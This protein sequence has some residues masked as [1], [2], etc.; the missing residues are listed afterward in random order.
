MKLTLIDKKTLQQ[1]VYLHTFEP[2]R[3]LSWKAGQQMHFNLKH[4]IPD[5]LGTRR[6]FS[7]ASAP[8]EKNVMV[9]TR[10]SPQ[11]STFKRFWRA[12]Q[13]GES[14]EA[15]L[16]FG[17]FV[18]QDPKKEYTLIAS[19]IGIA[20]YRSMLMDMDQRGLSI[21]ATLLYTDNSEHFP[22]KEDIEALL[23][24]HPRFQVFYATDPAEEEHGRIK[25]VLDGMEDHPIY[26]SGIYIRKIATMLD[27]KDLA[28]VSTVHAGQATL[29][30]RRQEE[31][32]S[33][34]R[35]LVGMWG[36]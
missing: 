34:E 30:A 10:C 5:N 8:F 14:I 22:F 11:G 32:R 36:E 33:E 2:E 35:S 9:L 1:E 20:P 28:P 26:M 27:G 25:E 7:I 3:P 29:M 12:I 23:R 15:D 17:D 31:I 19:G 24:H 18:I 21:N 6:V 16:P 13:I 4:P